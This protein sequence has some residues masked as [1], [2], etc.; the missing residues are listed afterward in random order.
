MYPWFRLL[1]VAMGRHD[2]QKPGTFDTTVIRLRA[3]PNDLDLNVHVNNGRILSLADLGRID[4]FRRAGLL[5]VARERKAFPVI[6]D[7]IAKFRRELRAFERFEIHS[8]LIGWDERWAYLEHRFVK[9]GRVFGVVAIRGMFTGK[10]GPVPPQTLVDALG[11]TER[12]PP[13]PDWAVSF[14]ESCGSLSEALRA[15]ERAAGQHG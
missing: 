4:W 11:R 2:G 13:L 8:R 15:E 7:A 3:W 5:R 12:S 9:A 10:N 14:T 6:G 1:R